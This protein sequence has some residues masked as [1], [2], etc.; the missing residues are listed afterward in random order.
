MKNRQRG[1]TL[2]RLHKL[3]VCFKNIRGPQKNVWVE[4]LDKVFTFVRGYTGNGEVVG[5]LPKL[6]W[7]SV[8]KLESSEGRIQPL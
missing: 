1:T 4:I 7:C 3:W 8:A 6:G 5:M 2:V